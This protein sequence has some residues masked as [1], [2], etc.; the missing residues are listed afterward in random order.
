MC[1]AQAGSP[2]GV[3]EWSEWKSL[4]CVRLFSSVAHQAPLSMAFSRPE[5]GVGSLFLLQWL[6]QTQ[7]LIWGLQY[8][9]WILFQLNYQ[10]S[11]SRRRSYNRDPCL[12]DRSQ[13]SF[14]GPPPPSRVLW[15]LLGFLRGAELQEPRDP[16]GGASC[17]SGALFS[18]KVTNCPWSFNLPLGVWVHCDFQKSLQ[19]DGCLECRPSVREM[20]SFLFEGGTSSGKLTPNICWPPTGACLASWKLKDLQ[21]CHPD[22]GAWA[23]VLFSMINSQSQGGSKRQEAGLCKQ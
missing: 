7:E 17:L 9:R 3:L 16:E 8:C 20:Q 18:T 13:P 10:G 5:S 4:S 21:P 15:N 11:W 6:F 14:L 19:P 12:L 2:S 23:I 22:H 1:H